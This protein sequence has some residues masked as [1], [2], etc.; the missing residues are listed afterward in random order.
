M[1]AHKIACNS[2][3]QIGNRKKNIQ[4]P[5]DMHTIFFFSAFS[6]TILIGLLVFLI[7]MAQI[8]FASFS[9]GGTLLTRKSNNTGYSQKE[10][11]KQM[12]EREVTE[13]REREKRYDK[14][15]SFKANYDNS[16]LLLIDNAA[17]V[18]LF[19]EIITLLLFQPHSHSHFN[20][21]PRLISL[22]FS[23]SSHSLTIWRKKKFVSGAEQIVDT[24]RSVCYFTLI[25][26][27]VQFS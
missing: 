5:F 18:L 21:H 11:R 6:V 15:E 26:F 7:L 23:S 9:H 1:F 2:S 19:F 27:Q 8:N 24:P 13:E 16:F 20:L 12:Q 4:T 22:A 17:R 3:I 10:R 14:N 25:A